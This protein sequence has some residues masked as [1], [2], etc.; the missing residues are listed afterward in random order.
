MLILHWIILTRLPAI[1][2]W[3]QGCYHVRSGEKTKTNCKA[4]GHNLNYSETFVRDKGK[5]LKAKTALR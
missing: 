3:G 5:N 2:E 1:A 4:G